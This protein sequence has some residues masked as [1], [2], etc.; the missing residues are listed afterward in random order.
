MFICCEEHVDMA[1][2]MYVD[3]TEQA[4]NISLI[5]VDN[6]GQSCDFCENKAVYIVGN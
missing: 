3:E 1:I 5:S 6:S 2:D 4:P